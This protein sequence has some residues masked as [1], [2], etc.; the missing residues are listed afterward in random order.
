MPLS[1]FI[2][3][4][5]WQ[6]PNFWA[7][8]D[9][10]RATRIPLAWKNL[11]HDRVRMTLFAAGI[12]F[13]VVL[14]FI[15]LGCRFALLDS[16]SLLLEKL[17]ADLVVVPRN[18]KTVVIRCLFPR[19]VLE[20]ARGVAGVAKTYPLY[21]EYSRSV[22]RDANEKEDKR[23]KTRAIRVLGV[24]PDAFL[25]DMPQLDPNSPESRVAD[26]R[27]TGRALFD[28]KG[29]RG[30][31][32]ESRYGPVRIGKH[33]DLSG[34]QVTFSG[35][36]EL[37]SDFGANGTLIVSEETFRHSLRNSF[38]APGMDMIDLG[39]IRLT[40]GADRATVQ[41]ELQ[42]LLK[43][44]GVSVF[45]RDQFIDHEQA[46]WK[47]NTPVGYIFGFGVGIGFLVGLVICFQILSGDIRDN[48]AAYATLRAI[49]YSN[50][51]LVAVVLE[52]SLLLAVLGF[53]PG[54]IFSAGCFWLL[55]YVTEL[56]MQLTPDRVGFVFL[57][58]VLM[59]VVSGLIAVRQ[60]MK[61]DPAEVF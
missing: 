15:Q 43:D 13:A 58:T 54:L 36:V 39:L 44:D 18:Q 47:E 1:V 34:S 53:V 49:G 33:S 12:G 50:G 17:N 41:R 31:G 26:L 32:G 40:P 8:C 21:I 61:V 20:R 23:H 4:H 29:K 48:I 24:D 52:E 55:G 45:T 11:T 51:Y 46:F 14:M 59:C 22:L 25:I 10:S 6:I 56:P 35:F 30:P 3:V 5:L 28:R 9:M 16:S 37:G 7:D 2:C 38:Y 42:S 60:A 27:L 57:L 19:Q